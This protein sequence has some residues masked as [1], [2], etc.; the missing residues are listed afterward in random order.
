[1][2]L[3]SSSSVLFYPSANK[4]VLRKSS[5]FI[6]LF[7]GCTCMWGFIWNLF[8][9][10]NLQKF[11]VQVIAFEDDCNPSSCGSFS[12]CETISGQP[13]CSCLPGFEGDPP[14]CRPM[15]ECFIDFNCASNESCI[16]QKCAD[17]CVDDPCGLN[18][19]CFVINHPPFCD[20]PPEHT[21][22]PFVECSRSSKILA[23]KWQ[24]ILNYW[25]QLRFNCWCKVC[26]RFYLYNEHIMH[27]SKMP[28][29]LQRFMR[30]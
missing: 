3:W 9:S 5:G 2:N 8:R 24:K 25:S 22:D 13:E 29:S 26:W 28:W 10:K 23:L 4:H 27:K 1:M 18:A 19:E 21:G 7:D 12:Y 11:S 14:D 15:P 16:Y 17:P 30:F 20:C 6:V